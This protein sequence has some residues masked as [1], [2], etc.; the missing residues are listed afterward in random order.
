M[1]LLW[2]TVAAAWVM[3]VIVLVVNLWRCQ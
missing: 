1:S 2:L 3:G